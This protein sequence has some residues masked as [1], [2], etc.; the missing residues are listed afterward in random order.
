MVHPGAALLCLGA[1]SLHFG[2]PSQPLTLLRLSACAAQEQ[3]RIGISVQPPVLWI[4]DVPPGREVSLPAP[5]T[6]ENKGSEPITCVVEP[7]LTS[8]LGIGLAHGYV[9]IPDPTWCRPERGTITLA[10]GEAKSVDVMLLVPDD[11]C[12]YN[13]HWCVAFSVRTSSGGMLG[14]AAYPYAYVETASLV[15]PVRP[16]EATGDARALSP[17]SPRGTDPGLVT[18]GAKPTQTPSRAGCLVVTP[19]ILEAGD[20]PVGSSSTAGSVT[21]LNGHGR[22]I[23]LEVRSLVPGAARL[24]RRTLITPGHTWMRDTDWLQPATRSLI[25]HAG[26]EARFEV[27]VSSPSDSTA[28]NYR[29]EGFVA[30]NGSDGSESLVRVRWRTTANP[31]EDSLLIGH[32]PKGDWP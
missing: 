15:E 3:S 28:I 12:H 4:V 11:P 27:G 9:D 20:V 5:I 7:I 31:G 8:T 17:K 32:S 24:A 13:R 10:A 16:P 25:V 29:W 18:S 6:I 23:L 21:I 1:L 22:D 19:G 30:I 26:K 2:A 14:A